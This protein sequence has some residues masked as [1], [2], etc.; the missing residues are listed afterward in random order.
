MRIWN[1]GTMAQRTRPVKPVTSPTKKA[2]LQ[3]LP[4]GWAMAGWALLPLRFFLGVTLSF[5]A[6]QKIANPGF[7][8]KSSNGGIYVQMLQAD[9]HSPIAFLLSHL[10]D[11]STIVGW[12]M[13]LGE[14]AVG[15][16][17]L[18]GLW[19]RIAAIGGMSIALSLFLAVSFHTNPYYLGSDIAFAFAF[20]PFVIA[21]TPVLSL[22]AL[23]SRRAAAAEGGGDPTLVP[24]SFGTIRSVC[25]KAGQP[26]M[27]AATNAACAPAGCPFLEQEHPS[28]LARRALNGED[29]RK[30]VLGGGAAAVTAVAAAVTAA[31]TAGVGRAGTPG[32]TTTSV[33]LS[34]GGH[35]ANGTRIGLASQV[36]VGGSA[37]FTLPNG[38]QGIVLQAVAGTFAAYDAACPHQGC[39]VS[40]VASQ[41]LLVCPCHGS[42]FN[43]STGA[44]EVGPA[45]SGLGVYPVTVVNGALYIKV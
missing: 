41:D 6:L 21:G 34:P 35:G 11:K 28:V 14:L 2:T 26:G 40:F 12:G 9:R 16:G 17:F 5:A 32:T 19:G 43:P 27:C 42:Q 45:V 23:I 8:S 37:S 7:F 3:L 24:I 18:L 36:P 39:P 4:K 29:R 31:V 15:I 25:G 44:V 20:M 38:G 13:A 30:V 10:I 33:T 22:D 1:D